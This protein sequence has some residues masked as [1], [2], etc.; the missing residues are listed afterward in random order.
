VS[1][2]HSANKVSKNTCA[3]NYSYMK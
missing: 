3:G 1:A 2:V